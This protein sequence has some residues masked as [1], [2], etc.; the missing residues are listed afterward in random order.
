[1]LANLWLF[2]SSEFRS[3]LVCN[4]GIID[5][6]AI[7][8]EQQVG[9]GRFSEYSSADTA[10]PLSVLGQSKERLWEMSKRQQHQVLIHVRSFHWH[11][12]GTFS[13]NFSFKSWEEVYCTSAEIQQENKGRSFIGLF[14]DV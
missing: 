10:G 3:L 8:W 13:F 6:V 7:G 2:S 11:N 14:G 4:S 5:W 9:C 1:M 12:L